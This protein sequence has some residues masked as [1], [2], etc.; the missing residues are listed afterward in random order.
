MKK[1][2][3]NGI[4]WAAMIL[5]ASTMGYKVGWGW[6]AEKVL[7]QTKDLTPYE[8]VSLNKE[9]I[10]HQRKIA[11]DKRTDEANQIAQNILIEAGY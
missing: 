4:A 11:R 1:E 5:T 2:I 9:A 8:I 7:T 6:L 10:K 3:T